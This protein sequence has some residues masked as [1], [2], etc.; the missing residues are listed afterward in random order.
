MR[1][2]RLLGPLAAPAAAL[3]L[4]P[5]V[6]LAGLLVVGIFQIPDIK[7]ALIGLPALAAAFTGTPGTR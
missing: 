2:T 6:V 5:L 7:P 3:Q 4:L 1:V